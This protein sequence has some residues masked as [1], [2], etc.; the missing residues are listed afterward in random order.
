MGLKTLALRSGARAPR[1]SP[2][3]IEINAIAIEDMGQTAPISAF[4]QKWVITRGGFVMTARGLMDYPRAIREKLLRE[5]D[6]PA[7]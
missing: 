4:Y 3:G 2:A 6:K 1:Q 5:L 7:S